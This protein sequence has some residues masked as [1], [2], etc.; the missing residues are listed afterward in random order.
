MERFSVFEDIARR[1]GGDIYIGVVGPVR[2]GKSTFV[3]R[4]VERVLV[5]RV[6]D[7]FL[8]QRMLDELPQSAGGRTVMTVEP[9]FVPEDAI[10]VMVREEVT[11]R[12]RLVDCVGYPVEGAHGFL[13]ESGQPRMVLTP[14]FDHEVP[15]HEAAELGTRRVVMEHATVAVVVITDGT[16]AELPRAA[17]LEPEERVIT[18]LRELA[19]PFVVVLNTTRPYAQET[20]EMAG[21]LEER[22]GAPVIPISAVD[23]GEDDI[24]LVVEQL[25]FEF[26]VKELEIALP[27]WVEALESEHWLRHKFEEAV[28][29]VVGTVTRVRDVDPAVERLSVFEFIHVARLG[30]LDMGTGIAV[31][32]LEAQE[33]LYYQVLEEIT[34]TKL[35]GKHTMV[36][37]LRE[38]AHA[39]KEYDKIATAL[40]EVR[41]TGYGMVPPQIADMA[42]A[43]PELVRMGNAFGVRLRAKAPSLHFIRADVQTEVTPTLGLAKQGE[44][45]AH[46]LLDRFQD[47]PSKLWEFDIFG[48]SLYD[49]CREGIQAKLY[50]MPEDAQSKLQ[51]TLTRII[52]EGSG[53]LICIII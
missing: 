23:L 1:T 21:E 8:R 43:E 53:G 5:P 29:E 38:W 6:E 24:H 34:G 14:W 31:I 3:R 30:T 32:E 25:L 39:K 12:V 44:D 18:E 10:E 16:V 36:R 51:E 42:F 13:D 40:H 20:L 48:K 41:T 22:Y 2:T 9:K 11:M 52:N 49:L 46:Y 47:D 17:Y 33:D 45:L 15:F 19:K 7:E 35:E 37:L 27:R 28:A 26:P 4:F 50:R